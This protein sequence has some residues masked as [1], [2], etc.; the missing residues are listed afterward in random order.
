M[1]FAAC[2]LTVVIEA[3]FLMLCGY[4]GKTAA[5]V[6]VCTNVVTNLLLN[7][8]LVYLLGPVG[9]WIYALEG[10]VV[11]SEY[12]IYAQFFKSGLRLFLLTLAANCLSYGLGLLIF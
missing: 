9:S 2:A 10:L 3:P 1:L 8:L 4:R 5:T 6:I 7:M 11:L 12:G